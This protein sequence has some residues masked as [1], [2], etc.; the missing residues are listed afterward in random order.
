LLDRFN[1]IVKLA[2][3]AWAVIQISGYAEKNGATLAPYGLVLPGKTAANIEFGGLSAPLPVPTFPVARGPEQA[4]AF[5]VEECQYKLL[6]VLNL[7]VQAYI[8]SIDFSHAIESFAVCQALRWAN[9][10]NLKD[11]WGFLGN[12]FN[13]IVGRLPFAIK[14]FL[15]K[16]TNVLGR[17][18]GIELLSWPSNPPKPML[19][20]DAPK[21]D[22]LS[23]TDEREIDDDTT[24]NLRPYLQYLGIA[25]RDVPRG[26]PIGGERFLNQPHSFP[27]PFAQMQFTYAQADVYNPTKWDMWTQDWRGQLTRS[28][29][30]DEKVNSLLEFL[31]LERDIDWSFVNNH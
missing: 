30:F 13:F 3:P 7:I 10:S 17:F 16:I 21:F 4:I 14:W 24:N 12:I 25:L 31:P 15:S 23:T 22:R 9:I 6:S 5:R 18:L 26:S 11:D 28:K 20:T 29:L 27:G 2:F 1:Q 19:L 8:T